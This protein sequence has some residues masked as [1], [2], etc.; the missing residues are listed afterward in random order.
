MASYTSYRRNR[1]S[2][3]NFVDG[4]ISNNALDPCVRK[5]Y[6]VQWVYGSL[7]RCTAGRCCAW[8]VPSTSPFIRR[9]KFELWG[10]GGN[11]SGACSCD[12]CHHYRGAGG[13]TYNTR[14]VTTAPACL[15]IVCAGGVYRCLSR[16]CEACNGCASYVTGY[17]LSDFCAVGGGDGQANTDWATVCFS[18]ME[19]CKQPGDNGGEFA[20]F[21]HIGPY[22]G[23]WYNYPGG[24]C[25]CWKQMMYSSGGAL[26]DVGRI[27]HFQ[28]LCWIRCGTACVPF[29]AGGMSAM[30]TY[31]GS[32]CC[33]QGGTGGSGVV[34]I[35][36]F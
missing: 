19:A 13:G 24:T 3:E 36:Y 10:A 1:L 22:S 31:C 23:S 17:N 25:H 14:T 7:G 12:R 6:C 8:R 33:G 9:V 28:Q 5:G 30:T 27:D 26:M 2:G 29:A 20:T 15:Y 4:A 21:N 35:T 18:V 11:G 34:K 16:N 32:S